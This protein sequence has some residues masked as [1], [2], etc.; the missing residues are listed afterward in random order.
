MRLAERCVVDAYRHLLFHAPTTYYQLFSAANIRC[1]RVV[2]L[3]DAVRY[4]S[5]RC[6]AARCPT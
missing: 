4:L 2:F 3:P 1:Q 6:D 5:M